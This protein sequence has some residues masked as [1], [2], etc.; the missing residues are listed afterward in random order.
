MTNVSEVEKQI[1]PVRKIKFHIIPPIM[2]HG[3]YENLISVLEDKRYSSDF[4]LHL[5]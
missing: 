1:L 4:G 3:K 2:T 5:E